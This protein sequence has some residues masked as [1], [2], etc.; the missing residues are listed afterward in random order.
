MMAIQTALKTAFIDRDSPVPLYHQV[1]EALLSMVNEGEYRVGDPI[2]TERE[3]GDYFQ[4]SRITVRRA[5]EDLVR[6][7]YL[8]T[9]QGKG[10][11]VARPKIQRHIAEMKSFSQEMEEEG[12]HPDSR[13]LSLRHERAGAYV[14]GSLDIDKEAWIWVVERLRLAD[15]E[16]LCLSLAYLHL[17]PQV[18]LTPKE[19]EQEKSLWRILER[20]G[21]RMARTE[22]NIQ[23]VAAG[24]REAQ[25]LLIEQG[26][27]LLLVEGTVFAIDGTPIE[28]HQI[29]N[30]GD[31]YKYFI[32]NVRLAK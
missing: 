18:T 10:T 25:L 20:K 19:L 27:P 7:G 5:I 31:R 30:R 9:R 16:P 15:D 3:L 8:I 6:E 14:A 1:R 28:F 13:L 21:V 29:Y 22:G 12:Y 17:P 4:V 23:A 26:A 2:L 32:E 24:D 11:Y